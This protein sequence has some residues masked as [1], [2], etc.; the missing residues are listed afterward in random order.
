M[1]SFGHVMSAL[2]GRLKD[3]PALVHGEE[4]VNWATFDRRTNALAHAFL[5]SGAQPGD[6]V[7]H[8][9]R[10]SPAYLTT[11]VGAFKARMVHVNVN[12]RYTGEELAYILGNSEAAVVVFDAEFAATLDGLRARLPYVKLWVQVGG[13]VG[14]A[15]PHW[16]T[17]FAALSESPEGADAAP[18]LD[19]APSDL[20]F[21]Y[22]GGT[23]GMPKAV[24][25]EQATLFTI[26]GA[27]AN[28]P[29]EPA[30]ASLEEHVERVDANTARRRLL[31]LPPLMHG[32]GFLMGIYALALGGTVITAA[33]RSF[34]PGEAL[35]LC[36]LHQPDIC[37]IVGDAFAR[38]MLRAIES[39][40]GGLGALKMMISSGTMWSPE[41][42]AGLLRH[43]PTMI[44]FDAYGSSEGLG[45]GQAISTAAAPDAPT[46]FI[47]DENKIVLD[48][49]MQPVAP[50]SGRMGRVA[51]TGLL[52]LGYWKDP[53]KTAST[54][55]EYGGR[56]YTMPGDW[57]MVESDG[58]LTLLGRGSQC[59]NTGGEKVFPEEVE[60]AL[61]TH[62]AVDDAL[63]FGVKDETWGQA[64]NAVVETVAPVSDAELIAHVKQR[65][66]AYKAPK[67][68]VQVAKVPR[69]PNG[70]ADY[71]AAR[72]LAEAAARA[73]A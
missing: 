7:A 34:D 13:Q 70:K 40:E 10:N 42:K 58:S 62:A 59:I 14:G 8:L 1:L 55:I 20:L 66:A 44:C 24:M 45:Y 43:C 4:V 33:K 30:P 67:K 22:T 64:V 11:T 52:P 65:L 39:G 37:V 61:K 71:A 49:D 36:A 69:A 25:W 19:H 12:Y 35:R 57:A 63:V 41:V 32:T 31:A 60:E 15:P 53:E 56:R 28:M 27:G 16:A 5:A 47:H 17:S 26:L 46:R 3:A 23:T 48:E 9:M 6:R 2:G 18:T 72:E 68:V 51:R 38:P 29:G 54:F 73:A 50:G 21:I